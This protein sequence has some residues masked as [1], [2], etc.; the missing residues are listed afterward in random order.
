MPRNN[1]PK[2]PYKKID[3]HQLDENLIEKMATII[4][5]E[6]KINS[7][8][9]RKSLELPTTK[10]YLIQRDCLQK[11]PKTISYNKKEKAY[12]FCAF[13]PKIEIKE[14]ILQLEKVL[15]V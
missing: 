9:L 3:Y 7:Y 10:F 6:K 2:R 8:S 15:T 1:F 11:Y 13:V 4:Q 12:C 5:D 14:K